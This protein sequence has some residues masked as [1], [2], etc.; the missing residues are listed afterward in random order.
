M[1]SFQTNIVIGGK[2]NPSLHNAFSTATKYMNKTVS[3]I[4]KANSKMA[5]MS[6]K[7]SAY[8]SKMGSINSTVAIGGGMAL[9]G[10]AIVGGKAMLNE[11]SGLEQYRNTLNIVMKDQRKAAEAYQ[12]AVNY[13]NNTPFETGELVE[14]TV[15]LQSYGLEAQKVLPFVGDMASAMGKS[16]DQAVEAMA[17]AQ[18]GELERLKEFGITKEQIVAQADKRLQGVQ[19]VNNKGQITNQKAFN[20]ALFSLMQDR[21]KGGM[22]VQAQSFAGIMSTITGVWK[23]GIAQMA[24]MSNSGE[25]VKGSMFDVIKTKAQQLGKSMEKM[26]ANGTFETLQKNLGKFTTD[27]ANGIDAAL[28]KVMGFANYV[29]ANGPQIANTAIWIGKAFLAWKAISGV[30][31]VITTIS[32]ITGAVNTLRTAYIPLLALKAKDRAETLMIHALYAK[33]AIVKGLSAA[34]TLVMAGAQGALNIAMAIGTGVMSAFGAVMAFVTSPI[35]L[36]VLAIGALIAAGYLLYSNWST[37][38]NFVV[39]IW[40]T[41]VMPFFASLGEWFSGIWNGIAGTFKGFLNTIISGI[42][43]V[44]GKLNSIQLTVPDWVPGIGGKSYGVNIP[45]IPMFAKGGFTDTPSIFGEAGPEVAIPIK[46]N[47]PRSKQ[48]L[49]QTAG[50]LGVNLTPNIIQTRELGVK[51]PRQFGGKKKTNS[52]SGSYGDRQGDII[53]SPQIYTSGNKSEVQTVLNE[54]FE[55]FK[56]WFEQLK[57]EEGRTDFNEP[58]FSI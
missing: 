24:G 58:V 15:K 55:R 20:A 48:L 18:T 25:I 12:W 35:G 7:M 4:N 17:D 13:A 40:Q 36:V 38:S 22:E 26:Q 6:E 51:K 16:M 41:Y 49:Y 52:T 57:Q 27:V 29:M 34:K 39:G 11:A 45:E 5:V 8:S 23:T 1:K 28:P 21:F 37:V 14:A 9:G 33:D 43:W 30:S 47:N 10:A 54:D 50:M 31:S 56:A 44:I 53:Y 2:V 19:V 32:S 42:N 3:S 46:R